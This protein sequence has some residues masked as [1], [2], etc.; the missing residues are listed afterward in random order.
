MYIVM[1]GSCFLH[2]R[3]ALLL[4]H[5]VALISTSSLHDHHLI[6]LFAL[7]QHNHDIS[8]FRGDEMALWEHFLLIGQFQAR[9]HRFTCPLQVGNTYRI[10]YVLSRGSRCF[11]YEF[12]AAQHAD[13]ERA[14]FN[15]REALFEHF[16][17][18]GQFERRKVRFTCADTLQ[19]LPKGFDNRKG[20]KPN[21]IVTGAGNQFDMAARK[22][23]IQ[24]AALLRQRGDAND[25]V[26]QALKG[27]LVEEAAKD[28]VKF[29][30][31]QNTCNE[32]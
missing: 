15:T 3:L 24:R 18:F 29:G 28:A 4:H 12:Y 5:V 1:N 11:D 25:A 13:L 10:A 7:M 19:H 32:L 2:G 23:A 16:A 17:E 21:D 6:L 22:A 8:H 26:Q 30:S 27:A 9:M 20:M 31:K 14:G